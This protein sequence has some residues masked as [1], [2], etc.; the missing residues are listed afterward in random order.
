MQSNLWLHVGGILN[1]VKNGR[2]LPAIRPAHTCILITGQW[3]IAGW[4]QTNEMESV[5]QGSAPW[6][7]PAA[8]GPGQQAL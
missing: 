6:T 4:E 8:P 3:E 5:C 2:E 1:R 7:A